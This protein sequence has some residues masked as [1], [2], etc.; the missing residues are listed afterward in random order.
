LLRSAL[1]LCRDFPETPKRDEKE[2]EL[3]AA[4]GPSLVVTQGY[5]SPEVG[6][7][8]V[9]GLQLAKPSGGRK[10]LFTMLSG[11]WTFHLV[12][13]QLEESRRLAQ[14]WVDDA[15]H[16]HMPAIEMTGRFLLGA[17]L[18]HQGQLPASREQIEQAVPA[19]MRPSHPALALFAAGPNIGVFCK[20]YLSHVLWQFGDAGLAEARSEE[21]IGLARELSDPFSLAFGLDYAAMLDVFRRDGESALAHAAEASGICGKYG[22]TYYL[23]WADILTGWATAVDDPA[24]GLSR[25]HDGL[26]ALKAT[27]AELRLP[28][29][30]GL[31][32][33]ACGLAGQTGEALANVESAFAFQNKNG[34]LWFGPELHRIQGDVLTRMGDASGAQMSYR[35]AVESARQIGSKAAEQRAAARLEECTGRETSNQNRR[36]PVTVPLERLPNA[37]QTPGMAL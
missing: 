37:F 7:T 22:F 3:L 5:S 2:L 15:S 20:A 18:F 31:V 11:A 27:G 21:A 14:D 6:E 28:F 25:L 4:L 34:E 10:H 24:A 16:D 35:R 13:G 29:Y 33:E 12:R 19:L 30:H 36:T 9:R 32:A 17:S 8:Y 23:A 1:R 26:V